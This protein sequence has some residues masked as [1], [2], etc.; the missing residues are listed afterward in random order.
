LFCKN[1]KREVDYE[2]RTSIYKCLGNKAVR[3]IRL[4]GPTK[5][6]TVSATL[7]NEKLRDLYRSHMD[8][9]MGYDE[10]GT[11]GINT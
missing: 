1:A 4:F 9:E 2:G 3:K 11:Q 10:M 7:R 5:I 8:S 6:K